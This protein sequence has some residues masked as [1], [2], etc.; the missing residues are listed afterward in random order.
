[1]GDWRD[2]LIS[3]DSTIIETLKIIDEQALQIALVVDATG[4]LLGTVTD[5]DVRRAILHGISFDEP[6]NRIMNQQPKT[7]KIDESRDAVLF[8]MKR[9]QLK[10]IP[11]IDHNGFI[12]SLEVLNDMIG[13]IRENPVVLMAGGLG[14]RLGELTQDCP[15]PLLKVGDKPILETILQNLIEYGF[16]KFYLSVNYKAEMI[17]QYFGDGSKWG[18]DIRYIRENKRLGTAGPLSLL[19]EKPAH[20]LVVMNGDLLTKVNFKHLLD[21]HT[22]HKSQATMCVREYKFQVPYGVVQLDQHR[23]IGI[24]EKPTQQFFVSAGVYVLEPDALKLIPQRKFFDMPTLFNKLVRQKRETAAF[25]IREYWL[26]IGHLCD[27]E[28]ANGEFAEVFK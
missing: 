9:Y 8:I 26:D 10:H 23:L 15:K 12:V 13:E 5:G 21:F 24:V 22:G 17:E 3:T 4:R 25:P 6:V 20:P 1:M 16:Y 7:V 11:V 19:P 14:T 27:F 28:R 18:V 2:S